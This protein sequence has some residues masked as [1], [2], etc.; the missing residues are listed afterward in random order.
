MSYSALD[1]SS[2]SKQGGRGRGGQPAN[3]SKYSAGGW[4]ES[5]ATTG[6]YESSYQASSGASGSSSAAASA[7]GHNPASDFVSQ[8]VQKILAL[9]KKIENEKTPE[10]IHSYVSQISACA[11][12]SR[13]KI[14]ASKGLHQVSQRVQLELEAALAKSTAAA[15]R[16]SDRIKRE[17]VM[18]RNQISQQQHQLDVESGQGRTQSSYAGQSQAQAQERVML[19]D[20]LSTNEKL[21]EERDREL[22]DIEAAIYDVNSIVKDLAEK[23]HAQ[24]DQM[25]LIEHQVAKTAGI[26]TK[27]AKELDAASEYQKSAR[28]KMCCLLVIFVVIGAAIAIVVFGVMKK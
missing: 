16:A 10:G 25:D 8:Q 1:G 26:T 15:G 27:A 12:A 9:S 17:S 4:G 2:T 11:N 6:H 21:I 22:A 20:E 3:G 28:K 5:T 24:G 23:V 13:S 14:E 18:L 19:A 7:V